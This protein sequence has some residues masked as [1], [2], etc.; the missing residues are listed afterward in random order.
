[1]TIPVVAINAADGA[2]L[3]GRIAAGPT[4]LT[5]GTERGTFP[6]ATGNL[7]SSFSSYGTAPRSSSSRT[8][9]RRAG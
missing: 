8:S 1:M 6:N 9:V 5:W 7:I 2:I 3:D 4:T